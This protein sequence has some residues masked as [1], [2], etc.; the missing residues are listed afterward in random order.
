MNN[1]VLSCEKTARINILN[2]Y[3]STPLSSQRVA[4]PQNNLGMV[5]METNQSLYV[6]LEKNSDEETKLKVDIEIPVIQTQV[7]L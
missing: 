1:S 5:A 4:A 3:K 2:K 6:T 7:S